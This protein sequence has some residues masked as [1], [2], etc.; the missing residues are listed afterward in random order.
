MD[1]NKE[2]AGD[3]RAAVSVRTM[4]LAVAIVLFTVGA[5]VVYDSYRLGSKWGSGGPQS[6]FFPF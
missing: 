4:E 5:I 2:S 3:E 1:Q 6:G